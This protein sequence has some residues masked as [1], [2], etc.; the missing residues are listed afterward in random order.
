M[1][2]W[3]D[4]FH[5]ELAAPPPPFPAQPVFNLSSYASE[6]CT[7]TSSHQERR[8]VLQLLLALLLYIRGNNCGF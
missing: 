8:K 3:A 7:S 2:R 1:G 6:D 4:V 5:G